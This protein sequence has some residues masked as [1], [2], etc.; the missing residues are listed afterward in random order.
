MFMIFITKGICEF[1]N[2]LE[3]CDCECPADLWLLCRLGKERAFIEF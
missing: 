2:N 1:V 3:T